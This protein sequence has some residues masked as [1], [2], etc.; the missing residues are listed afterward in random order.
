MI[1]CSLYFSDGSAWNLLC[2]DPQQPG[3]CCALVRQGCSEG[4]SFVK[5]SSG[6]QSC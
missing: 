4:T 5:Q 2:G 6:E 3:G 1:P